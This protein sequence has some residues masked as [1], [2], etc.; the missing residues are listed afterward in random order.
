[1]IVHLIPRFA[2]PLS[3]P[4]SSLFFIRMIFGHS[5]F[6]ATIALFS[7]FSQAMKVIIPLEEEKTS[8]F[9]VSVPQ[10]GSSLYFSF[11][12]LQD[13]FPIDVTITRLN[14]VTKAQISQL[15]FFTS[16]QAEENFKNLPKGDYS[17]TFL[18]QEDTKVEFEAA[19]EELENLTEQDM[20]DSS[21]QSAAGTNH[22]ISSLKVTLNHLKQ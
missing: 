17:I 3:S 1:S 13:E 15:K 10:E 18:A 19:V 7:C 14:P 4:A 6:L 22:H 8:I 16:K 9:Y 2:S 5:C 20:A 21:S 12:N 11:A